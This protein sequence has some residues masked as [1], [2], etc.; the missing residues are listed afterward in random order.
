MTTF[1]K[2]SLFVL[3]AFSGILFLSQQAQAAPIPPAPTH[4]TSQWQDISDITWSTDL[5]TWG[6]ED[7]T[8]GQT[9]YFKFDMHKD[10]EG[11]HYADLL[12][13]W[14]DWDQDNQFEESESLFFSHIVWN[15]PVTNTGAGTDVDE[16]HELI[17]A[18]FTLT[19]LNIGDID[20]LVRVTCSESLLQAAGINREWSYQWGV[21]PATYE[22]YFQPYGNLWQ[23]EVESRTLTVNAVPEPKTMLLLGAG[24]IGLAGA[25]RRKQ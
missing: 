19:D 7:L 1:S 14:I 23:G 25:V 16:Y 3:L 15:N 6:N 18:G 4:D 22:S 2:K 24:L 5:T 21:G 12:K 10:Y 9:V 17:S 8:V 20:I 11:R 13:A